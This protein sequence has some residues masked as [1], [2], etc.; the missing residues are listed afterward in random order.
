MVLQYKK[1]Y[2]VVSIFVCIVLQIKKCAKMF[3]IYFIRAIKG[4]N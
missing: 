1:I 3:H 2:C 4:L